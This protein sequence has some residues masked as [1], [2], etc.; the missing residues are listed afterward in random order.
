[1]VPCIS[2]RIH[3]SQKCRF[4]G[5]VSEAL[6]GGKSAQELLAQ[7]PEAAAAQLLT[8]DSADPHL[9]GFLDR[10]GG[11]IQGRRVNITAPEADRVSFFAY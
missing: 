4:A 7:K 9:A 10:L 11:S 6:D 3:S 5:A 8:D 1:M 2:R